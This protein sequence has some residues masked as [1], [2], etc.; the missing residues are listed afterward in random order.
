MQKRVIG[1]WPV[2]DRICRL[3]IK[4]RFFNI[5]IINIVLTLEVAMTTRTNSMRRWSVNTIAAHT[6]MTGS[7]S[8]TLTLKLARRWNTD[9]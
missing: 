5:S 7:S 9:R 1:W 3:R 8:A 6:M 4:G 2:S